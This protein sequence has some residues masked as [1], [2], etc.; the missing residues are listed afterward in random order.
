MGLL[1]KA[2]GILLALTVSAAAQDYPSKP[3]RMVV[4]FPPGA[5][6]D[7]VGRVIAAELSERLGKQF[8]VDNRGGAGGVIGAE[9]VANAPKDGYTLLIVSLATAVNPHLYK[10][11]FEP[12][13]AFTPVSMIVTA[14]NVVAVYPGLPAHSI[15]EL[16]ALAKQQPGALQ[17]G[18]SGIGT[19]VHLGGELFKMAA[20]IDM[21]HVPF[22]GT[23]PAMIDLMAGNTKVTFGSTT[24]T[25]PHLRSGRVRALALGGAQR[26]PALPDLPTVTEA[27]LPYEASNWIGLVAP[28]GTPAAV[29]ERLH[30]EIASIQNSP[31]VQQQLAA[32]GADIARMS[33][34]EFGAFQASELAKWGK[35]VKEAGI[36]AQ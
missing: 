15:K 26:S 36:K 5:L 11:P 22:K 16:I 24:S 21:L 14:P 2:A 13:K 10:L 12:V 30:K 27:G 7:T 34:A 4:P 31:K 6:N 9:V 29:V 32:E 20:G 3:V 1:L 25:M 18:S 8:I 28:A 33:V 35:V 19:F 23:A 17:Y